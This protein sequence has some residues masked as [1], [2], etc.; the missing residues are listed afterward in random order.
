MKK[1]CLIL[2]LSVCAAVTV[3]PTACSDCKSDCI[4]K[5]EALQLFMEFNYL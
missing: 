1:I 5:S 2:I 4:G 3:C